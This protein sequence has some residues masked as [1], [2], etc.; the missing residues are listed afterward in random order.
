MQPSPQIPAGI[1]TPAYVLDAAR[2]A[3][4]V[5]TAARIRREAGAR[6]LLAT[7]AFAL[8]AAFRLMTTA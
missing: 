4:N 5:A 6:V 1:R 8:P 2:L 3:A 7:K